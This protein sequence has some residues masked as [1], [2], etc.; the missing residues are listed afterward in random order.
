MY[1]RKILNWLLSRDELE[2]P[3]RDANYKFQLSVR[4][5]AKCRFNAAERLRRHG[6]FA[7]FTTTLLSLGLIFIPLIQN[8]NVA[9]AF[10]PAVL[11]MMSTFLAVAVLVYSVVIGTAQY[12]ARADKL[13]QCGDNLKELNRELELLRAQTSDPETRLKQLQTEYA[14]LLSDTENH[15][16]ID[17]L[18]ATLEMKRDYPITGLIRLYR[19][20]QLLLQ[21]FLP[22]LLPI[23]LLAL[24]AVFISDMLKITQI[25]PAL[26]RQ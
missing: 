22:Y 19:Q 1:R 3:P 2:R 16:R 20:S 18:A 13:S 26:L 14:C 12:E 5:T 10:P 15:R 17:Y 25:L 8:T 21:S 4:V 24:E 11:N 6:R 23:L 7:F 9:L